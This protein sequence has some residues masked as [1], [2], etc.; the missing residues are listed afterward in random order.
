ML[1]SQR[2]WC[3]IIPQDRTR[4]DIGM[5]WLVPELS[6]NFPRASPTFMT[7]IGLKLGFTMSSHIT[8]LSDHTLIIVVCFFK[9]SIF[10]IH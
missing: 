1:D 4:V 3:F 9:Y 8:L 6:R 10:N 5:C 7:I 2:T